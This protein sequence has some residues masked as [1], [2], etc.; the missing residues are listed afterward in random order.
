MEEVE[1]DHHE[2]TGNTSDDQHSH[3][4]DADK[5][6]KN[7]DAV[8]RWCLGRECVGEEEGERARVGG[9]GRKRERERERG[10]GGKR[11]RE[12]ALDCNKA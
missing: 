5:H 1:E 2:Y 7:S 11:G 10:I 9:D 3:D 4:D 8:R 6:N 12:R